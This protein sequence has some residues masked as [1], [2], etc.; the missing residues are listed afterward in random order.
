M[1]VWAFIIA[2]VVLSLERLTYYL[3][4]HYPERWRTICE[5]PAL[6]PLGAPVHVLQRLFYLFKVLQVAVFLGW[7]A[8]FSSDPVPL[9]TAD[10]T[11]G[12]VGGLLLLAGLVL[13]LTVFRRLGTTGV[14]YGAQLGHQVA[15]IRGFPFSLLRH[16][17]YVGTLLSIWGFFIIMRFPHDDWIVLPLLETVYY[18]VGARH[19]V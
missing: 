14:F 11:S 3:V 7:C 17:Q 15:W 6:A 13:N 4:S 10:A 2:A 5:H 1:I 19:E 9:P 16:P 18:A 12:T 8:L